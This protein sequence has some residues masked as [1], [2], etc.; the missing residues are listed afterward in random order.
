MLC[1]SINL[2][3][4]MKFPVMRWFRKKTGR[5]E[6]YYLFPQ[7]QKK[8]WICPLHALASLLY[9]EENPSQAL[10][11]GCKSGGAMLNDLLQKIEVLFDI[12][13]SSPLRGILTFL[14]KGIRTHSGRKKGHHILVES[15]APVV[16]I[17]SH[18]SN[19][20][21]RSD[22]TECYRHGSLLVARACGRIMAGWHKSSGADFLWKYDRGGICADANALPVQMREDFI[23]FSSN[24]FASVKFETEEAQ[25]QLQ[26]I[27]AAVLVA[28]Y[29]DALSKLPSCRLVKKLLSDIGGSEEDGAVKRHAMVTEWAQH[30]DA[31]F[32]AQNFNEVSLRAPF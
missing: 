23:T 26:D 22:V 1:S 24:A 31:Y 10:F 28:S 16:W 21:D 8:W 9:L 25:G 29:P 14:R 17:N 6:S 2:C 18:T 20:K 13:A 12:D 19:S 30:I 5:F 11:P 4:E 15:G 27:L 32:V 3:E 7:A